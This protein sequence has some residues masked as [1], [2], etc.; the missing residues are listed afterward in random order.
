MIWIVMVIRGGFD[1]GRW[2]ECNE[3]EKIITLTVMEE[4]VKG[5]S[6]D[7]P[8]TVSQ[9]NST[10][11]IMMVSFSGKQVPIRIW[12]QVY[13]TMSMLMIIQGVLF[14]TIYR[15]K[16]LSLSDYKHF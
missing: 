6:S 2:W 14:Y 9:F 11:I 12:V 15:K 3:K 8:N 4:Q 1:R 16:A 10:T 5:L 7:D 13:N